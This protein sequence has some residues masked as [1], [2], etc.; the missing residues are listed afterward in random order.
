MSSNFQEQSYEKH[1][2]HYFQFTS[3]GRD[4]ALAK[5][6]L[7]DDTVDAWRHKRMY[8]T[9]DPILLKDP[10]ATWLTIGDGRYGGDA[11]YILEKGGKVIASDISDILL[12][13][14]KKAGYITDYRK[15]NAESLSFQDL[16]FDYVFCKESYHHFPRPMLALYEM[17]R[18]SKK[19]VVLIEPNDDYISTRVL[20]VLFRKIKNLIKLF[21]RKGVLNYWEESGNY[22]FSLSK[23][24]VEKV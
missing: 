23:R 4:E 7:S 17:L 20:H 22:G 8:K 6:W 15:E 12:K 1:S 11:R 2:R 14:A 3:G 16:Q 18:V 9:I 5:T 10:G 21:L 19:A 13:E 24:E